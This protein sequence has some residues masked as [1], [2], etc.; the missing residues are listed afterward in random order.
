[1]P[2]SQANVDTVARTYR[3]VLLAMS[4]EISSGQ[5]NVTREG[6]EIII[7]IPGDQSFSS[8]SA[9]LRPNFR[10]LL[11]SIGDML[12]P[13]PAITRVEGHTDNVPLSFGGRYGDNWDLSSARAASVAE[14]FLDELYLRPGDI[15]I[16]A[17][18]DSVPVATNETAEG[19][20]LNRRID[21]VVSPF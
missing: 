11:D 12:L 8:G 14:F 1:V 10:S 20:A 4:D 6:E 16:M 7:R 19:R 3:D 18:A 17:F 21:I 5:V 2:V 15:Y 9:Q 13:I